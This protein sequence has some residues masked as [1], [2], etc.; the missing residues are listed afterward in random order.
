MKNWWEGALPNSNKRGGIIMEKIEKK[1][2]R[3]RSKVG[4]RGRGQ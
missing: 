2:R 4:D 3:R 1:V